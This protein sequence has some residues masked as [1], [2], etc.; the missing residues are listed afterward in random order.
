MV[1]VDKVPIQDK[2]VEALEGGMVLDKRIVKLNELNELTSEV[3]VL[4]INTS[5]AVG[6][7]AFGL[8][9]NAKTLKFSKGSK[10]MT[11]YVPHTA[12]S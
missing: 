3:L 8:E 10:L 9:T 12:L 4:S 11:K 2:Y 5:S 1:E 7:A 6:K